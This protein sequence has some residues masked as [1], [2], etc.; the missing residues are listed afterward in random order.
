L[1]I[2]TKGGGEEI[3]FYFGIDKEKH[4]KGV[5]SELV[6]AFPDTYDI[7]EESVSLQ[8][9]LTPSE[10]PKRNIDQNPAEVVA[11]DGDPQEDHLPD[12]V[13]EVSLADFEDMTPKSV[14]WY[15]I[16][17]RRGDWM[18]TLKEFEEQVDDEEENV[19]APLSSA[20]ENLSQI[21]VP[22]AFQVLWA[23]RDRWEKKAEKRK[24]NIRNKQDGIIEAAK[25][26]IFDAG[27]EMSDAEQRE[28]HRGGDPTSVGESVSEHE[29][30]TGSSVRSR[31]ALIDRKNPNRTFVTNI[32]ATALIPD[33]FPNDIED[34]VEK[35]L[36]AL[37]NAFNLVAGPFYGV[38][39]KLV[40]N[41]ALH[42]GSSESVF[43]KLLNRDI[44]RTAV[45][46]KRPQIILSAD[47]LANFVTVPSLQALTREGARGTRGEGEFR[48]PLSLPDPD[49]LERYKDDGVK[50]T[51]PLD[52]RRQTPDNPV[53]IPF[54]ALNQHFTIAAR[55]GGGK[56]K[57]TLNILLS[58]VAETK[59]PNIAFNPKKDYM[60]ENYM[61]V[62]Y[63]EFGTLDDVLYFD[64]S[65]TLPCIPFFDIRPLLAAG[66]SREDAIEYKKRQFKDIMIQA[67]GEE[68]YD[69]AFVGVTILNLL[70]EALF[71]P[72][73]G[74]DA[75]TLRDLRDA[76]NLISDE[77]RIPEV[78]PRF[79]HVEEEL[80]RFQ[81]QS[82]NAKNSF[83][84]AENRL[85]V[86]ANQHNLR[87]FFNQLP[88]WDDE[89]DCY[90]DEGFHFKELLETDKTILFDIGSLHK[91]TQRVLVTVILTNIWDAVRFR[92]SEKSAY[93]ESA[94]NYSINAIIDEAAELAS[95]RIVTEE[96]IPQGRGYD[97]S[98]GLLEQFPDQIGDDHQV[99]SQD[100]QRA[101]RE[102]LTNVHTKLIG[103]IA[104][105]ERQAELFAH[106]GIDKNELQK[107]INDIAPGYW[108][109]VLPS[110]EFFTHP[111]KPFYS[112]SPP[113]PAGHPESEN[114]LSDREE[115]TFRDGHLSKA[116]Q[117]AKRNYSTSPTH[118]S[119]QRLGGPSSESRDDTSN[120]GVDSGGASISDMFVSDSHAPD[121]A[122]DE[123]N[124]S[125]P[126]G[127]AESDG[128]EVTP[129]T[130]A[131][132][133][134]G[135]AGSVFDPMIGN[136]PR[137]EHPENDE[138]DRHLDTSTSHGTAS[139]DSTDANAVE[140]DAR[141][142]SRAGDQSEEE[143]PHS[144][145]EDT[146]PPHCFVSDSE[147][148]SH[149]LDRVDARFLSLVH[150]AMEDNVPEYSL[151][152]PMTNLP[153]YDEAD[154][155]ALVDADLLE[156]TNIGPR[157]YY[158]VTPAGRNFL[159]A[160]RS[161]GPRQGDLGE[162]TPHI[163]GVKLVAT[164]LEQFDPV[165][166][167][168]IYYES[169]TSDAIFDVAAFSDKSDVPIWV[170]EVETDTN[171]RESIRHDYEKMKASPAVGTWAVDTVNTLE[172]VIA[173]LDQGDVSFTGD[174][175]FSQHTSYQETR[176]QLEE[177]DDSGFNRVYGITELFQEV[178]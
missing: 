29:K 40:D 99:E 174:I 155:D 85:G 73:H 150:E 38:E 121:H 116:I 34:D 46:K 162:K 130:A 69:Q 39:G 26:Q 160:S 37:S 164:F 93:D 156:E 58:L 1:L 62:H 176:D 165:S 119:D 80:H 139:P 71:D 103:N 178:M 49:V 145:V 144:T 61:R 171:D 101:Y 134:Q 96:F 115:E 131:E 72:V 19:R 27:T 126:Q 108:Y 100:E 33:K 173:A 8:G 18:T 21:D 120:K 127:N 142:D 148:R 159:G 30:E 106:E 87:K 169:N 20:I 157:K 11:T 163:V 86:I 25:T 22:V 3:K 28:R 35:D 64:V 13:D 95:T 23:R 41:S 151:L 113:I 83:E 102:L 66:N 45:R 118:H 32:R 36:T 112:Q 123:R 82:D 65:E 68:R 133:S 152:T 170:G 5:K 67:M 77:G 15:G 75:F 114:P 167:T 52:K 56:S 177:I 89:N 132:S 175:E 168:E 4:L 161:T 50:L 109:T 48:T 31:S 92:Q 143:S 78:S 42:G 54:S 124:N 84:A 9:E 104:I 63:N 2:L 24:N 136:K 140:Q 172:T 51:Y 17:E 154:I 105:T 166:R 14:R 90:A 146:L 76:L 107:R 117:H 12:T 149:G 135:R 141:G 122:N 57:L 43:K 16:E 111:P 59:G 6:A 110:A 10:Y 88:D 81:N 158:T 97:I 98:L 153:L 137:S 44:S 125:V 55:S 79:Q 70:I 129:E 147:I 60:L 74:D 7:Y 128:G 94:E 138:G 53:R 47:E 91:E